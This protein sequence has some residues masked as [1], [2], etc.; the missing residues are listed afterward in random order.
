[1]SDKCVSVVEGEKV[2]FIAERVCC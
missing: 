1:M 2:K